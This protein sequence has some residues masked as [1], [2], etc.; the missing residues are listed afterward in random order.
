[1]VKL[2]VHTSYTI[3]IAGLRRAIDYHFVN[4][5]TL[6][7]AY[8]MP[9]MNDLLQKVG[10]ANFITTADCRSGYWQL[11][12]RPEDKCMVDCVRFRWRFL[13]VNPLAVWFEDQWKLF[14]LLRTNDLKSS[15]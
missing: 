10:S 14:C 1:M 5:F 9:S 4:I 12:V 6:K 11:P 13:G 7:D 3:S 15:T 2:P 8:I